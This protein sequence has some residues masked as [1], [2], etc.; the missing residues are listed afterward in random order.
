MNHLFKALYDFVCE[1]K[2]FPILVQTIICPKVKELVGQDQIYFAA[3][4]L[5]PNIS[6]GHIKQWR[7]TLTSPYAESQWITEIRY[8]EE[9]NDCHRR[10]VCCKEL[11]HVFDTPEERTNSP[12]KFETLLS[13]LETQPLAKDASPMFFSENKT[14]WMALAVLCP[15]PVRD[16]FLPQW[17][18][19]EKSDYEVALE[20]RIPEVL[21]KGLMSENYDRAV[22]IL[23]TE[24]T[25]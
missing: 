4:D 6:L 17:R 14:Q 19:G 8:S 24:E 5:D 15:M 10:Y 3:V 21:I 12:I 16:Y 2:E 7:D 9:L 20:L 13:E 11:M 25:S 22:E 18:S 1:T 23:T